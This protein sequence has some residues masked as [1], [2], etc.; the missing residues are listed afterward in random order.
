M[1]ELGFVPFTDIGKRKKNKLFL[2]VKNEV[3]K[4]QNRADI[5]HHAFLFTIL[6]LF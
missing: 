4:K 5:N 3:D 1:K 6:L 2:T